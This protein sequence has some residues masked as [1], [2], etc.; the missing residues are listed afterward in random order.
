MTMR[1]VAIARL[2]PDQI[3][4]YEDLHASFPAANRAEMRAAGFDVVDI[5]RA[6]DVLAMIVEI[7]GPID[8]GFAESSLDRAWQAMV[9]P[10]LAQSWQDARPV[11]TLADAKA[12][13]SA[14]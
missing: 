8:P 4:R 7:S 2:K 12:G 5:Y 10:C 9:G 14:E 3:A 13:E 6:G 1:R 11:F